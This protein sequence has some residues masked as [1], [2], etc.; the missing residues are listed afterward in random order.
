MPTL[1]RLLLALVILVALIYGAMV[2]LVYLVK[3]VTTDITIEI[4][5]ENLHL[6]DRTSISPTTEQK[7]PTNN[8]TDMQ[9]MPDGKPLSKD[10]AGGQTDSGKDDNSSIS[11]NRHSQESGERKEQKPDMSD[12][13]SPAQ[14]N[15]GNK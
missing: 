14:R 15:G 8:E 2:G 11:E 9:Q 12:G 6:R 10:E 1:T 5:P 3:P 4:Q 13:G 7:L